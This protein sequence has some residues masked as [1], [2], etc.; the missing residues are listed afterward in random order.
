MMGDYG[1][2]IYVRA[3]GVFNFSNMEINPLSS[4]EYSKGSIASLVKCGEPILFLEVMSRKPCCG[5]VFL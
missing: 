4:A 2:R 3:L 1:F 5:I